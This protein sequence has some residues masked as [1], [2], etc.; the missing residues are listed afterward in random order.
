[1]SLSLRTMRE[2]SLD[3]ESTIVWNKVQKELALAFDYKKIYMAKKELLKLQGK[4]VSL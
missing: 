1:M 3:T 2:M 4:I